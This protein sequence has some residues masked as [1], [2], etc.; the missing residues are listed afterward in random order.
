MASSNRNNRQIFDSFRGIWVKATP[1]EIVRQSVLRKMVHD[2]GYPRELIAVEKEIG[3]LVP[4]NSVSGPQRRIDIVCF[5][6]D[7]TSGLRP[8]ILI[9]CKDE[10]IAQKAIDQV[11]GYN[12]FIKAPFLSVVSRK[13]EIIGQWNARQQNYQFRRGFPS[14]QELL[15]YVILDNTPA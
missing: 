1:E 13:G 2:L 5:K 11:I 4:I 8:L 10:T 7:L 6:K 12:A 3:E 9:E 14:Y 15:E